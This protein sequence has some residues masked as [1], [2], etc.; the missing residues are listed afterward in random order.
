MA[1]ALSTQAA[2]LEAR[3]EP[4]KIWASWPVGMVVVGVLGWVRAARGAI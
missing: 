1:S 2:N 3:S 4:I